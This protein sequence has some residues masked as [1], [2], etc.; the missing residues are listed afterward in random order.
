MVPPQYGV[1]KVGARHVALC[2]SCAQSFFCVIRFEPC[3][4]MYVC[5]YVSAKVCSCLFAC[6]LPGVID[7]LRAHAA[8]SQH[9]DMDC[10]HRQRRR[11]RANVDGSQRDLTDTVSTWMYADGRRFALQILKPPYTALRTMND[12]QTTPERFCCSKTAAG[13]QHPPHGSGF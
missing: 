11:A 4:T 7:T 5:M 6:Q 1:R 2:I 12:V 10:L 13:D 3:N 8:G 9:C